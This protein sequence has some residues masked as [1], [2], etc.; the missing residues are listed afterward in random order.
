MKESE[1]ARIKYKIMDADMISVDGKK[2]IEYMKVMEIIQE[3]WDEQFDVGNK[4]SDTPG[5]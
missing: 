2:Y 5:I 3:V 4:E 1:K